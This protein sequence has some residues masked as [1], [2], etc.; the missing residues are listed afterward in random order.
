MANKWNRKRKDR[1]KKMNSN[2]KQKNDESARKKMYT[3]AV[4]SNSKMEAYYAFQGLHSKRKSVIED[5]VVF[6]PCETDQEKEEERK[7]WIES[8]RQILPASFRIGRDLVGLFSSCT[9]F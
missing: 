5:R 9:V 6:V 7:R 2:K 8:C 4:Q 3:S 1:E